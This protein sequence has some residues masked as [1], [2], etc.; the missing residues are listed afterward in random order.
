MLPSPPDSSPPPI[1]TG[2]S[3]G[4]RHGIGNLCEKWR[5]GEITGDY[6]GNPL[7][8]NPLLYRPATPA[9][10]L[11]DGNSLSLSIPHCPFG[12]L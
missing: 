6:G 7:Y 8:L 3:Q 11:T 4:I 10:L 5:L 12:L 1:V 9:T 2:K